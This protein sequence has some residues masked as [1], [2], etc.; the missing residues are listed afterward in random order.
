MKCPKCGSSNY[1]NGKCLYINC[2]FKE[3]RKVH[4][5][6]PPGKERRGK[7]YSAL[8]HITIPNER[9]W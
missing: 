3:R 4:T 8:D 2:G 1:Q 9:R 7:K 5:M 6:L